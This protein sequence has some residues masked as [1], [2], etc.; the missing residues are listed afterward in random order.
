[1]LQIDQLRRGFDRLEGRFLNRQ[2][3]TGK[4]QYGAVMVE[5]G[6]AV[7]ELD[8]VHGLDGCD[9]LVYDLRLPRFGKV[10]DTFDELGGHLFDK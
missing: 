1:V 5:V 9:D 3:R 8:V 7:E 4:R 10:R 6:R 2:R